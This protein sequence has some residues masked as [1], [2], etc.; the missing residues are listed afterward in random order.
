MEYIVSYAIDSIQM[1]KFSG[2]TYNKLT[3]RYRKWLQK[4]EICFQGLLGDD[5]DF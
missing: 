2:L 3:T 5:D 4:G 1:S